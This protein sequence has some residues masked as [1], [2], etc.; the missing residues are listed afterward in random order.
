MADHNLG[1]IRG[2]IEIDYDG[3]GVVR[4]QRDINDLKKNDDR[5]GKASSK[6]LSGFSSMGKGA[7]KV[8]AAI[9]LVNNAAGLL[10]GTLAIVGPLAAAG[11]A[12]APAVILGY[13]SVMGVAKV[14][15]LGVAEA[16]SAAGGDAKEFNKSI[17]GLS[18]NAK[19]FAKAFRSS[20]PALNGVKN[21]MQDAFFKGSAKQVGGVVKAIASLKPQATAVA[22][23]LGEITKNFAKSVTS[24]KNMSALKRILSGVD[25]FLQQIKNSIGP[26]V[27]GFISLADQASAFGAAAGDSTAG[28]LA[29]LA[30]WLSSID[31][32]SIFEDAIPI[33]KSLGQFLGD[34]ANIAKDLFGIFIGDGAGA[35]GVLGTLATN[36]SD[37]LDSA[38]G[39][40]ALTAL[41]DAMTSISGAVG[42]AFLTLLQELSPVIVALAPGVSDL[43]TQIS[44]VLVSALQTVGPLLESVA[45]FL[46][47][48]IDWLGPLAI[49]IG[50][51][52]AAYKV[53]ATT[54]DVVKGVQT[55]LNSS[56]AV[57]TVA[58]IKNTAA[59]TA[60]GIAVAAGAIA[61][62][63]KAVAGFVASTAAAVANTVA[64]AAL[65]LAVGVQMVGAWI[66]ATAALVANRIAMIASTVAMYAARAA[67]IAWTAAQWLLNAALNANPIALVVIAIAALVAGLI[68][69]YNHSEKFRNAV[70]AAWAAIKRAVQS[71]VDWFTGTALPAIIGVWNSIAAGIRALKAVITSV[72]NSIK[73]AISAAMN[74]IVSVVKSGISRV[75]SG[76]A[77]VGTVVTTVRNAFNRAKTAVSTALSGVI[78]IVKALPGKITSALGNLGSLLYDKGKSLVQGFING[79]KSMIGKVGSAAKSVVGAVT[80]FL[81]GSPAEVG[82]LSGKGYVLLRAQRFVTDFA[83]G[84]TSKSGVAE[85]AASKMIKATAAVIPGY[86]ATPGSHALGT[87]LASDRSPLSASAIS[88]GRA[89]QPVT[90]T[91]SGSSGGTTSTT[92]G[93][94]RTYIIKIGTKTIGT[95]MVDAITG[96]PITVA[97]ATKAGNQKLGWSGSG[98]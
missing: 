7:L 15:T 45:G 33:V 81:P 22:G 86:T 37:F 27:T 55:A 50:A 6:V 24:G 9:T 70:N 73:N 51:T 97:K 1:S 71:V 62:G 32:K 35:A 93:G 43:A 12:A 11:F 4:A 38:E 5:L 57:N 53:Y 3:T 77:A 65:N 96:H 30:N 59:A 17:K 80:K 31:V 68:Y 92:T 63:T 83:K 85:S 39:Q 84:I 95:L 79:I 89:T 75:K 44:G 19:S 23:S 87:L 69:A 49:A 21:S 42:D 47:D 66:S 29:K 72:W 26:V 54:A 34:V 82:P 18:P 25:Q 64:I 88:S 46:S 28:G 56:M 91:G 36:L 74:S 94:T 8:G 14:A 2:T 61:N 90:S 60:N 58:W 98:R 41:R 52:S 20:I 16:L 13:A 78:S 67:A 76:I 48:N 10:G 40:E